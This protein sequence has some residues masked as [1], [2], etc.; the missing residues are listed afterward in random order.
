M[1]HLSTRADLLRLAA[2]LAVTFSAAWI[3]SVASAAAPEFYASLQRPAWAPPA[4]LFGPVWTVLYAMMAVAAWLVWRSA[5]QLASLP[6][7]LYLGQLALNALW[8]WLFFQWQLGP[9]A[10]A[11]IVV[12][13]A[14]IA[15]TAWVFSRF[16]TAAAVLLMPYLLWVTYAA[17]LTAALW[18]ANPHLL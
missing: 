18:R 4:W 15:G 17:A 5:G 14:A 7:A 10:L 16:S 13:W 9:A 1:T 3:G 11:E 2:C 8:S 6:T 12:L